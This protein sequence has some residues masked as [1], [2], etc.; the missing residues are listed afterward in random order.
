MYKERDSL[1]HES[2]L[3][4]C[5]NNSELLNIQLD[6]PV[7]FNIDSAKPLKPEKKII[8][9]YP[10]VCVGLFLIFLIIGN[11]ILTI[12]LVVIMAICFIPYSIYKEN[13]KIEIE[14]YN[15]IIS[16]YDKKIEYMDKEYA[17]LEKNYLSN[18]EKY[19]N[20]LEELVKD[21]EKQNLNRLDDINDKIHK[22]N[23]QIED[24]RDIISYNYDSCLEEII[25]ILKNG[26]ANSIKDAIN[27]YESDVKQNEQIRIQNEMLQEE[28]EEK[29]KLEELVSQLQQNQTRGSL[30][31]SYDEDKAKA[32][33]R[34]QCFNCKK[35]CPFYVM[36][37]NRGNCAAYFPK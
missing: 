30:Y 4:E 29:N 1:S 37:N 11:S 3:E 14:K 17:I 24:Y 32:A 20:K 35:S 25:T 22:I 7:K 9:Y 26:R 10:F 27:I 15:E 8:H 5:K 28:R 16:E 13:Y 31:D 36:E 12:A 34:S 2:V 6:K 18:L 23:I 33:G 19:N 21:K